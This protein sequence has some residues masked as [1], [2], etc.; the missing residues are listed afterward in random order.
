MRRDLRIG[1]PEI[2]R[3]VLSED[4]DASLGGVVSRIPAVGSGKV[5]QYRIAWVSELVSLRWVRDALFRSSV[6]NEGGILLVNH[7]RHESLN[8]V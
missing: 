5:S 2:V 4:P 7:A 6:H 3:Q 1:L 8:H